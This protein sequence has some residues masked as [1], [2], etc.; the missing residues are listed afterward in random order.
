MT[1]AYCLTAA[2]KAGLKSELDDLKASLFTKS[3][4]WLIKPCNL[5][6]AVVPVVVWLFSRLVEANDSLLLVVWEETD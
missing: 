5:S 2:A 4:A 6:L 3:V 1:V